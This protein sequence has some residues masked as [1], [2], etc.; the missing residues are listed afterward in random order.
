M[1]IFSEIVLCSRA[2]NHEVKVVSDIF[3]VYYSIDLLSV[4]FI[5]KHHRAEENHGEEGAL[6]PITPPYALGRN[7]LRRDIFP[8]D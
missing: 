3:A 2:E 8:H 7:C 5:A 6:F 4:D 1:V